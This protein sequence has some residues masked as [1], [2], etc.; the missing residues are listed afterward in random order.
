MSFTTSC[1]SCGQTLD[2]EDEYRGWEVRCPSC[3]HA[4]VAEGDE[5]PPRRPRYRPRRSRRRG[6]RPDAASR[7]N[8]PATLLAV[9][10]G[11][12]CICHVVVAFV[13]LLA[14]L[15]D[16]KPRAGGRGGGGPDAEVV[17]LFVFLF[18]IAFT[19]DAVVFLGI[20][21]MFRRRRYRV[22]IAGASAALFPDIGWLIALIFAVWSLVVLNDPD[23]KDAFRPDGEE[24][25]RYDDYDD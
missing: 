20:R 3:R 23:V 24:Y 4:F 19:K 25:D 1:P 7:L 6:Y 8:T 13:L 21:E 17:V 14:A 18:A 12:Q 22:A 11:L 15:E 9:F 5:P 2:V 10:A 16:N